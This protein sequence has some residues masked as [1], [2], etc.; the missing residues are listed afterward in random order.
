M[1]CASF[2]TPSLRNVAVRQSFMHNG[3]FKSLRDAVAF[4]ATRAT[5]PMHWY[6]S[7][8]QFEDVPPKFRD[9]VN[10][11]SI[12]YNRRKGDPPALNDADID[13]I[14]SFLNTLTDAPYRS[15][16]R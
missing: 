8:V 3:A 2:R 7:D 9:H 1:W 5:D 10:V 6:R 11:N 16:T 13:A 14:V 15:L 4:Y 12:P